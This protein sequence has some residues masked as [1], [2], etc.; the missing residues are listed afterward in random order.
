MK[1]ALLAL[2]LL[3]MTGA[4]P[5]V[6]TTNESAFLKRT[7]TAGKLV[8]PYRLMLPRGYDAKKKYPLIVYLH[9]G[10]GVGTDNEKQIRAG[11][12]MGIDLFVRNQQTNPAFILA[13]QSS[14]NGWMMA[15]AVGSLQLLAVPELIAAIAKQYSIDP[16]RIYIGGQS[17]GGYGTYALVA[18][19]PEVFAAA[20]VL[21]GGGDPGRA[22][23][24]ARVPFW[25]F[26]GSADRIVNVS[27]AYA[28]RDAIRRAGGIARYTEYRGEGHQI[29]PHVTKEKEL[30][31]WLFAQMRR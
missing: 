2:L 11:N 14:G 16:R 25:I 8:M 29:W 22:P 3:Q 21:C 23:R 24:L 26:H 15:P 31:A 12:G 6:I 7:Y 18:A 20:F 27:E 30:P 1:A 13:P 19:R 5:S 28:M 17:L 9:G 4:Q 10:A